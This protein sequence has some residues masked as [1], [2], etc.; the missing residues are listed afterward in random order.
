M[1]NSAYNPT[2][3]R[4]HEA[5]HLTGAS[6]RLASDR[7]RC[8]CSRRISTTADL[9]RPQ[10]DVETT[11]ASVTVSPSVRSS[12]H[13]R[14]VMELTHTQRRCCRSD[15]DLAEDSNSLAVGLECG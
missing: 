5:L 12:A 15:D 14:F 2:L 1:L 9:L 10:P 6:G 4:S 8:G 13:R 7:N 11:P 3:W